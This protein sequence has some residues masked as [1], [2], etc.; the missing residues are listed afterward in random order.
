MDAFVIV[1][2]QNDFLPG[3]NLAVPEGDGVLAPINELLRSGR[4]GHVVATRDWHPA[5][6]GSFSGFEVADW[7][8]VDEPGRWLAHCVRGTPGADFAAGV[9]FD[10]VD[11]VV[12]KGQERNIDG[13]SAFAGTDLGSRLR[14]LGVERIY[15][16][17]LATDYCVM[18]TAL[19]ALELGFQVVIVEDAVRA[20]DAVP[21]DGERA[22]E[23]VLGAG[24][25][26]AASSEILLAGE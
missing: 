26:L 8:G 16:A 3:G 6:H 18:H 13:Y 10:L 1:D 5:D 24:C 7:K 19:D 21:R 15:V 2:V 12:D 23:R 25:R 9:D 17:G 22:K 11:D 20:V 14:S 4:F